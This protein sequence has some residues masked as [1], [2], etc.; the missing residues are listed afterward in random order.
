MQI[1][2]PEEF[3]AMEQLLANLLNH[4]NEEEESKILTIHQRLQTVFQNQSDLRSSKDRLL[5]LR[6][7]TSR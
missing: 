6:S 3:N 7:Q 5:A 2:S 4:A 1:I